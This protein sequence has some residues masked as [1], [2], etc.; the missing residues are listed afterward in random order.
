MS[1]NTVACVDDKITG[2]GC[3]IEVLCPIHRMGSLL[4]MRPTKDWKTTL[5]P[6]TGFGEDEESVTRIVTG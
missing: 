2:M 6:R 1:D 5:A 4:G 3:R